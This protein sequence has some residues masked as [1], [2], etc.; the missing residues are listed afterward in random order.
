MIRPAKFAE[1]ASC[2]PPKPRLTTGNE[3]KSVTRLVQ[4]LMLELPT[5]T[6][7]PFGGGLVLSLAS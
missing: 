7:Q 4:R 5:K 2:D 6:I 3:G 1:S